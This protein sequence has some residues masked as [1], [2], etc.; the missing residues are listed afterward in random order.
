MIG[1]FIFAALST[2]GIGLYAPI[3]TMVSLLGMNPTAAFP[4]MMGCGAFLMPVASARFIWS[5]TYFAPVA[6]GLAFGG[7][8]GVPIAA[9]VV[10][11]LPL[12]TLRYFVMADST[13]CSDI[14]AA[15]GS[16]RSN[17]PLYCSVLNR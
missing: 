14:D 13:L 2:L 17:S 16:G 6:A 5:K 4:I 8:L 10:K 12:T 11:S 9:F 7:L 15:P 1:N 3:M